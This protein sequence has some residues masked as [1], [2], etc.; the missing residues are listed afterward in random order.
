MQGTAGS[1]ASAGGDCCRREYQPPPQRHFHFH[2][3]ITQFSDCAVHGLCSRPPPPSRCAGKPISYL[4]RVSFTTS[5][6]T[7]S[8]SNTLCTFSRPP[9]RRSFLSW[10]LHSLLFGSWRNWL[11]LLIPLRNHSFLPT[12][13]LH[14]SDKLYNLQD[15]PFPLPILPS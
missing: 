14:A 4:P 7:R 1:F 10:L 12:I 15:I 13:V 2:L 8:I 9:K 3:L 5:Y 6:S 11:F